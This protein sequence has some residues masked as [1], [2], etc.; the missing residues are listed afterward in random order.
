MKRF[1]IFILIIIVTSCSLFERKQKIQVIFQDSTKVENNEVASNPLEKTPHK[2][3]LPPPPPP[4]EPAPAGASPFSSGS[5]NE[6]NTIKHR[7]R[8]IHTPLGKSTNVGQVLYQFPDTM[9]LYKIYNITVR[10]SKDTTLSEVVLTNLETKEEIKRTKIQVGSYMTVELKND[11]EL[12]PHFNITKINSVQQEIDTTL[13]TTWNFRVK[14]I[15]SGESQ[16]N[17][18]ISIING[19]NKKEIVYSDKVLIKSNISKEILNWWE[20]EW[21]WAF[22]TII[23]PIF[24]YIWKR[25]KSKKEDEDEAL[26]NKGSF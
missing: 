4:A 11:I 21:K 18:V 20:T 25:Y 5:K 24:I 1:I 23:I 12:D 19:D 15:K 16:L 9:T 8:N 3:Q 14:P 26:D 7:I 10:I 13:Y 17:L 2:P 22:T 6:V